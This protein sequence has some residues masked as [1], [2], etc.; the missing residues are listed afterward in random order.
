MLTKAIGSTQYLT[1]KQ[2]ASHFGTS[3]RTF[4]DRIMPNVK[5]NRPGIA[6]GSNL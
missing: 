1:L 2:A 3:E 6:G 4:R 5:V